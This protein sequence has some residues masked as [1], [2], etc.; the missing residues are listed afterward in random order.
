MNDVCVIRAAEEND[1][2]LILELITELAEYERLADQV[3][4]TPERMMQTLFGPDP[5]AEVL[6]ADFGNH[7]AGFALYFQNYSTFLGKPGIYLEDLFV[8]LDYRGKGVG[9]KL[10]RSLAGITVDRGC[11]RLDWMVLDWN[12]T[13][14]SFYEKLGAKRVDGFCPF[15]LSGDALEF[16]AKD[17]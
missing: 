1:V 14:I 10:L 9:L 7:C 4:A 2:D 15:R 17:G 13:A 16:F 5:A 3:V 12:E 11:E 6:I 8:R